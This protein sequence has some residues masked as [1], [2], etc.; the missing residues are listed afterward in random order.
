MNVRAIRPLTQ[1]LHETM[2]RFRKIPCAPSFVHTLPK[3]LNRLE[4]THFEYML[5][6]NRRRPVTRR[7]FSQRWHCCKKCLTSFELTCLQRR[8]CSSLFPLQSSL[9]GK[10]NTY[11]GY[12]YYELLN[13]KW[14]SMRTLTRRLQTNFECNEYTERC[15]SRRSLN[16]KASK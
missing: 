5:F 1:K 14:E 13:R 2:Y 15:A 10:M 4:Q 7:N 6:R 11:D 16:W 8:W 12:M 9:N 3:S